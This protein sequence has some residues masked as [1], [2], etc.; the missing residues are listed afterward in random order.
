[1]SP[2]DQIIRATALDQE[3]RLAEVSGALFSFRLTP[4]GLSYRHLNFY[5]TD[6][7]QAG[8]NPNTISS[9]KYMT[10]RRERDYNTSHNTVQ[11][12][13]QPTN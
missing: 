11:L 12:P 8:V 5:S 6:T 7:G 2:G 13:A 10:S 4:K 1:M 3:G 9:E